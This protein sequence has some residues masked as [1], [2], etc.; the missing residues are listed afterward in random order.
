MQGKSRFLTLLLIAILII[1]VLVSIRP[2]RADGD[3][4]LG[5]YTAIQLPLDALPS[6]DKD[7][8]YNPE[9]NDYP[10][11]VS[12][13]ILQVLK[14][15][16]EVPLAR[17]AYY[18]PANGGVM[19]PTNFPTDQ[20]IDGLGNTSYAKELQRLK[21]EN[22]QAINVYVRIQAPDDTAV[23]DPVFA[24][25]YS[26][27]LFEPTFKNTWHSGGRPALFVDRQRGKY[28][29][30][31]EK[32]Y[33]FGAY[34]CA[35]PEYADGTR[36]YR[37][38]EE[39]GGGQAVGDHGLY[40]PQAY[41]PPRPWYY[42]SQPLLQPGETREGWITCLAPDVP[43][44]EL[45]IRIWFEREAASQPVPTSGSTPT[46]LAPG[47]TVDECRRA[48][49]CAVVDDISSDA[50]RE[51]SFCMTA[52][53]LAALSLESETVSGEEVEYG[54]EN[55]EENTI[56]VEKIAWDYIQA[57][58]FPAEGLTLTD[59]PLRFSRWE[60]G[61]EVETKILPG[62]VIFGSGDVVRLD[63]RDPVILFVSRVHVTDVHLTEQES[64]SFRLAG[65]GTRL[66]IY[67]NPT[68]PY[69][70]ASLG[71]ES[72]W[73]YS[74]TLSS[75]SP[76]SAKD[77]WLA[78]NEWFHFFPSSDFL[79]EYQAETPYEGYVFANLEYINLNTPA[80]T[81]PLFE[82]DSFPSRFWFR[83]L[84]ADQE[85]VNPGTLYLAPGHNV[86]NNLEANTDMCD[87]VECI[88]IQQSRDSEAPRSVPLLCPGEWANNFT[89][90]G[91][92]IENIEYLGEPQGVNEFPDYK[93]SQYGNAI[94][95]LWFGEG[96]IMG[97]LS[98][99]WEDNYY[100]L[101]GQLYD[102][103]AENPKKDG[104][105][106]SFFPLYNRSNN[107]FY[108]PTKKWSHLGGWMQDIVKEKYLIT[109]SVPKSYQNNNI[110]FLFLKEGPIWKNSCSRPVIKDLTASSSYAP[111]ELPGSGL[112]VSTE[113]HLLA[114][115]L[116]GA[117]YPLSQPF[118]TGDVFQMHELAPPIF[119]QA[120]KPVDVRIIPG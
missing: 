55:V 81:Q 51:V 109:T 119:G 92:R 11:G 53:D 110:I 35:V 107:S 62:T 80:D 13:Q 28:D 34:H 30:G 15:P 111:S 97:G 106:A 36:P 4:L 50:C 14:D 46:S 39:I 18:S 25:Y 26:D 83:I 33:E 90:D 69:H 63:Q 104:Y 27:E 115:I 89:I 23:P 24:R 17:F 12:L 8:T 31:L 78:V 103:S 94:P 79:F 9:I 49:D 48:E 52:P 114:D 56:L 73:D 57:Y 59:V 76:G 117:D 77:D 47:Y 84:A 68:S 99:W 19:A 29:S 42:S 85:H 7:L 72:D 37:L 86:S 102:L 105:K 41:A 120:F 100:Q 67:E 44:H 82:D 108:I 74:P 38:P 95:R 6:P 93:Y 112:L 32:T 70:N 88:E 20:W 75:I 58:E 66:E 60:N 71:Q 1:G 45:Q 113:Q 116:P 87:F 43:L 61:S 2:A 65:I 5:P 98:P 21:G 118:I 64:Q 3:P 16:R 96:R 101:F 91:M 22:P 40:D 10:G 54:H